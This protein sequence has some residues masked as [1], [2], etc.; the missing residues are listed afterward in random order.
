MN[1][2]AIDLGNRRVKMKS[3]RGEYNYPA[4]YLSSEH[5]GIRGITGIW[6]EDNCDYRIEEDGEHSFIWGPDLG[7]Y[8]LSE[9]IIDA[10]ARSDR[11]HQKKAQR[12]LKFALGRLAL[13][14]K[15]ATHKP[16]VIHLM[17]GVPITDLHKDS[18]TIETLNTLL[19]G[20]HSVR[21]DDVEVMIEVPS[22]HHISIVP[23]YMGTVM[24]MA[25]D[26][27]LNQSL[28]QNHSVTPSVRVPQCPMLSDLCMI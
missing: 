21:I 18:K 5:I 14:Y 4:S 10:Y 7:I 28:S 13:D 2:F 3:D 15:E 27:E 1:I 12:L 6:T 17:L 8:N 24:E 26:D 9:K 16:L 25:F 20:T 22:E 19:V 23:Q 11:M